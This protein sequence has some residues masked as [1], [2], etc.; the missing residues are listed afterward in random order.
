KLVARRAAATAD[1]VVGAAGVGNDREQWAR[2]VRVERVSGREPQRLRDL[3]RV[4]GVISLLVVRRV[5]T[6]EVDRL[7]ALDVDDAKD[8]AALDDARPALARV[9]D[10]TLR[11]GQRGHHGYGCGYPFRSMR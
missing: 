8:A 3:Q 2:E 6:K 4:R 9:D 10:P 5:V 7:C 11:G 1:R